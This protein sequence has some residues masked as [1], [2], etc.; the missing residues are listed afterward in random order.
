MA[1]K[2]GD[3]GGGSRGTMPLG[4]GPFPSPTAPRDVPRDARTTEPMLP[5]H[6]AQVAEP[7][8]RAQPP[9][10]DVAPASRPS[11]ALRAPVRLRGEWRAPSAAQLALARVSSPRARVG[12][13]ALAAVAIVAL[14]VNLRAR[15]ALRPEL[16]AGPPTASSPS[17]GAALSAPEPPPSAAPPSSSASASRPA[18]RAP[19]GRA[20]ALPSAAH[21]P[22]TS[23]IVDPWRH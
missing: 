19:R 13:A 15:P 4:L 17:A 2:A 1:A 16:P 12:G 8:G 3:D 23:D 9:A 7:H 10:C 18:A 22:V 14:A 20:A 11:P 6:R 5:R 21:A